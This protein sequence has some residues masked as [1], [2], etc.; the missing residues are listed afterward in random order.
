[1]IWL[2]IVLI[3]SNLGASTGPSADHVTGARLDSQGRQHQGG[4]LE[5][6]NVYARNQVTETD[7]LGTSHTYRYAQFRDMPYVTGGT[8]PC[9]ACGSGSTA[10]Q[11]YDT[12]TRDFRNNLAT[13]QRDARGLITAMTEAVGTPEARTTTITWHPQFYLPTRLVEPI[14]GGSRTTVL[15]YDSEGNR[16][17]RAV[18]ANSQTVKKAQTVGTGTPKVLSTS[19][20]ASGQIKG[21]VLPSGAEIRYTYRADGR[22]LTIAVNGVVVVRAIEYHPMGPVKSWRYGTGNDRYERQ[23]DRDGRIKEHSAGSATRSVGFD[24]ASRITTITDGPTSQNRWT[25]GYDNLDR[26]NTAQNAA[27]A[28]PIANLNL[29]WTYDPTGKR[30]SETRNQNPSRP[31]RHRPNQQ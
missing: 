27:T 5:H 2:L 11:G 26:L 30:R 29:A 23:F 20:Q 8:E 15:T 1:M 4:P 16:L 13:H 7:P 18:T 25:Y 14:T 24:P 17:T 3:L 21:H 6:R 12:S 10:E 9:S 28:G 19:Y 22:V 31:P